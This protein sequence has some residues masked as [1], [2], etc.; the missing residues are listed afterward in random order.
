VSPSAGGALFSGSMMGSG[1]WRGKIALALALAFLPAGASAQDAAGSAATEPVATEPAEPT[2]TEPTATEPTATE[3][4]AAAPAVSPGDDVAPAHAV[5]APPRARRASDPPADE[6]DPAVSS[7]PTLQDRERAARRGHPLDR[8]SYAIDPADLDLPVAVTISLGGG[9]T[10][11]DSS[12]DAFLHSHDYA[13][14]SGVYLGDV[15]VL[16]RIFDSWL[17]LGG[18]FGGRART[19]V[20]N[21]GTGGSAGAMDLQAILMARVQLGRVID[22]GVHVGGG[23]A[24]VGVALHDGA[25][26]GIAPRLTGGIHVGFRIGHGIRIVLRGSYDFCR[27]FGIDRYDDE[28]ELGGPS[29]AVGLEIRS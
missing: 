12:Y 19:F 29:A 25:S 9:A 23:G 6:L 20:R 24:V 3:P 22:L 16:G 1:D 2:A 26:N 8:P 5:S 4:T 11:V 18:R 28:L 15:T 14:S 21:D 17:F 27:W 7:G 10:V 13:A